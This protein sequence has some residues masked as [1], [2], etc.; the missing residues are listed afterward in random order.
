[1]KK[2][3]NG[4]E[5]LLIAT[6]LFGMFFGAGNLIFP[7]YM[8]QL[9]GR[10]IWKAIAG[11][12][13]TGV[14]M[15]LLGVAAIGVSRSNGLFELSS[16]VSRPY[17]YFFTCALYLSIGPF[18][19][20]PRCA[21]VPFTVAVS[22]LLPAE[23]QGL[24]LAVFSLIFFALVLGFSLNPGK[25]LTYVGKV[26]TPVFLVFLA[27]LV[28]MALVNPVVDVAAVEPQGSYVSKSFFT[29]FLEAFCAKI[30]RF[31]IDKL[32]YDNRFV[33]Y[34]EQDQTSLI[35]D[36]MKSCNIDEKKLPKGAIKA[37]ISEAK[38]SSE[39]PETYI[40]QSGDGSDKLIDLYRAYQ[41]RLKE[42]NALDFDDLLLKGLELLEKCPDVL[43]KYRRKFRYVL[44][45][46]YQ[47]TNHPQYRIVQLICKEH[48]NICVVGDDDQ[49]IY[50][51]RGADIRNILEFE[52]DFKSA[53][54]IRLEQNYRSTKAI[55]DC[56]NKIIVHNTGR[57]GKN[58]WTAKPGGQPV[59]F[60]LVDN[61]RDE[62][63]SIA[64]TISEQHRFEK[65][66]Y[67]D[68]AILYRTH[69]QSRIIESVLATGFGIPLT[70]IGGTRFYSRR[71]VKDLLCYIKLIANPNDDVSF[72]RI[73]NVPK[74]GIGDTTIKTIEMAASTHDMSMFMICAAEGM[75]PPRAV[76]HMA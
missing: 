13:I 42:C 67:N 16:K 63:Y 53:K 3:L 73:I 14:S 33:I 30:L 45:D 52:K 47:D 28:V 10:N 9:A 46:E 35:T 69:A 36:L 4:R 24:A 8:G 19:A 56:A 1:M 76:Q 26:L 40:L 21:T 2:R 11:F 58:L 32:G 54:V 44:V 6:M 5:T 68:F 43:Q 65:R 61:E 51:W 18:F 70:V 57:K 60:K 72:K 17:G 27:I 38:N 25:I 29:G 41:K 66:S 12:I 20:I 62:A 64:R 37:K 71:E 22:G 59:E 31:D 34:D 74:R 49:S 39:A 48:Q 7:V 75:L 23:E 55:L 50:G 15:P